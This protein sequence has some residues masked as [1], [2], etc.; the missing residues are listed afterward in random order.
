MKSSSSYGDR[1]FAIEVWRLPSN[2]VLLWALWGAVNPPP[3]IAGVLSDEGGRA[4]QRRADMILNRLHF[5]TMM[6]YGEIVRIAEIVNCD[7]SRRDS[8]KC[9]TWTVRRGRCSTLRDPL[10]LDVPALWGVET[11][12]HEIAQALL[13]FRRQP[14]RFQ[15]E[16][17]AM[18]IAADAAWDVIVLVDGATNFGRGSTTVPDSPKQLREAWLKFDRAASLAGLAS[19]SVTVTH[20]GPFPLRLV[21]GR[22]GTPDDAA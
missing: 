5:G 22:D 14:P 17:R 1:R 11:I 2:P 9:F 20:N 15:G 19:L 4:L 10:G 13:P 8:A 6:D 21:H 7:F 12:H 3:W 16:R 18:R